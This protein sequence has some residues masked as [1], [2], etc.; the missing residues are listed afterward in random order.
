MHHH[1]GIHD[2][3][4][5]TDD[6]TQYG[7]GDDAVSD[8]LQPLEQDQLHELELEENLVETDSVASSFDTV[9]ANGQSVHS[10][11]DGDT[12]VHPVEVG[13]APGEHEVQ[14]VEVSSSAAATG[15]AATATAGTSAGGETDDNSAPSSL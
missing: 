10:L 7:V 3:D 8:E 9:D 6:E 5:H 11:E 1:T 14:E 2:D 15:D 13:D 12:E 4:E